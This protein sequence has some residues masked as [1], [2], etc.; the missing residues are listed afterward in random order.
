MCALK[1]VYGSHLLGFPPTGSLGEV[2]EACL[3]FP[4]VSGVGTVR[5]DLKWSNLETQGCLW[6]W[7]SCPAMFS[8]LSYS[9]SCHPKVDFPSYATRQRGQKQNR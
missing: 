8:F 1:L 3:G 5:A 6:H 9:S 7:V 4:P 2:V